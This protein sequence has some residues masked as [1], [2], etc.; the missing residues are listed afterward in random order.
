VTRAQVMGRLKEHGIHAM[1]HYMPVC[2]QPY[3]QALYGR[4]ECPEARRFYARQL[5]LPMHPGMGALDVARV[6]SALGQA[7][8]GR[9]S[10][11]DHEEK[12]ACSL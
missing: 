2:D 9:T 11:I 6:V 12:L 7:L 3:Y 1:V 10:R 8:S 4:A 5:S